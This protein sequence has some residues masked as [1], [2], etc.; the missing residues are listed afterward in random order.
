MYK[1]VIVQEDKYTKCCVVEFITGKGKVVAV[2][3]RLAGKYG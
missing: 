3:L 1:C 2:A